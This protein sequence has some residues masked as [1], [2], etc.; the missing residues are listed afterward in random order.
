MKTKKVFC[1]NCGSGLFHQ[2]VAMHIPT[3]TILI[4]ATTQLIALPTL[5]CSQCGAEILDP[6]HLTVKFDKTNTP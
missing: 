6:R 5:I 3:D 2:Y 4:G 1:A